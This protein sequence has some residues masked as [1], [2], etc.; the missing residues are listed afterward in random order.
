MSETDYEMDM[1]FNEGNA[2][3][4]AT[5]PYIDNIA[6]VV[7]QTTMNTTTKTDLIP[8]LMNRLDTSTWK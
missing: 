2:Y 3:E 7:D 6:A 8:I 1:S 5:T 4:E